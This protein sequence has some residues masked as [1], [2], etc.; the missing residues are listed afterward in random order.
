MISALL[1]YIPFGGY[2]TL[3]L[4]LTIFIFFIAFFLKAPVSYIVKSI[5]RRMIEKPQKTRGFF[6]YI[7]Q[8]IGLISTALIWLVVLNFMPPLWKHLGGIPL[9]LS[10]PLIW[11][12]MIIV[13]LL[14]GSGLLWAVYNLVDLV[15]NYFIHKMPGFQKDTSLKSHFQ[16]FIT[17]FVKV[18]VLCFGVLLV[19]QSVGVNV[20][21]LMAGLG[22]GGVA[23]ALAAKD[24]ASNVLAYLNIMIDKPFSVG[25][26]IY[27]NDIEGNVEEVGFRSCKIKTFYD[28]V[29]CVPN[30]TLASAN[31]DNLGKRKARRTRVY[32]GVQ[33]DTS[34]S[35]LELFIKEIKQILKNNSYVKHDYFQVY[36]TDFGAS[37]LKIIVNFFLI[38]PT[39]EVELEQKQN[40][41]MEILKAAEKLKVQFAFPTQT[42]HVESLPQAF[43]K[44]ITSP[45]PTKST[46]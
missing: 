38:V 27:F 12:L 34:P 6:P 8:P 15:I 45:L 14:I 20:V 3:T 1:K 41:F 31:I 13:K 28:S 2:M 30:A 7:E 26:W 42:L 39:W 36:F 22:I 9:F 17:R 19:L 4:I 24:S 18:A 21:S 46:K 40:V 5:L 43:K 16:P 10:Q 35:Q 37:E 44:T 11:G 29:I 32:L 25:D 33:Y 23:L